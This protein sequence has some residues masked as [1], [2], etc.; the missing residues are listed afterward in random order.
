MSLVSNYANNIGGLNVY[1]D[2]KFY[3]LVIWP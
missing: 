2:A 3:G 1:T